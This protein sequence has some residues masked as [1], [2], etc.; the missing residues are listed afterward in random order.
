MHWISIEHRTFFP[1]EK[2]KIRF[3][4][5]KLLIRW[6]FCLAEYFYI[7]CP[8]IRWM[9]VDFISSLSLNSFKLQW[10]S[11]QH[12]GLIKC[13]YQWSSICGALARLPETQNTTF[14]ES[15]ELINIYCLLYF[16]TPPPQAE[17]ASFIPP[18]DLSAAL[19]TYI[20]YVS[21]YN[22]VSSTF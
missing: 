18:P 2:F 20:I 5:V 4:P 6:K 3:C 19:D 10:F 13:W 22:L 16:Y 11:G 15:F 7:K 14:W 17:I 8:A 1:I 9:H 21:I 12:P